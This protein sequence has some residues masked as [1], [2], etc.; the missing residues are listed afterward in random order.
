MP[1]QAG[2]GSQRPSQASPSA[3]KKFESQSLLPVTIKQLKSAT[4]QESKYV[5]DGKI[6]SQITFVGLVLNMEVQ[7]TNINYNIDDGTGHLQ[8][9]V[10]IDMDEPDPVQLREG[11]YVRV[12]G[13]LRKLGGEMSVVAFQLRPIKDHNELTFHM[14]EVVHTHL[15]STRG[16]AEGPPGAAHAGSGG[17]VKLEGGGG[18]GGGGGAL[19][20]SYSRG[21][22][23]VAGGGGDLGIGKVQNAVLQIFN[24]NAADQNGVAISFVCD[25]L[26]SIPAAEIRKNVE[27]L[28]NEGHLYSTI[29]EEH[30]RCTSAE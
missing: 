22:P 25:R 9:R 29:D 15:Q 16:P 1:T 21:A 27:F 3:K 24:Q 10:Y 2:M 5:V 18:G 14:L 12:I 17:P 23:V 6:L 19:S 8:V 4:E 30:Y 7:S 26:P 28:C 13:N 11:Q 20:S